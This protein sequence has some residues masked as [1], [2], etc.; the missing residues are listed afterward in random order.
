M[1]RIFAIILPALLQAITAV[2]VVPLV[3]VYPTGGV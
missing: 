2:I 1:D 3:G